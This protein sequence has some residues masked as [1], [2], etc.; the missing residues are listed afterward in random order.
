MITLKIDNPDVSPVIK[1]YTSKAHSAGATTLYVKNTTSFS[2]DDKIVVGKTGNEKTEL[3][4]VSAVASDTTLTI[5]ALDFDHNNDTLVS[6]SD[7]DQVQIYMATSS[8]GTYS[9]QDTANIDWS[10]EKTAWTD[11]DGAS[12]YYYKFRYYNSNSGYVS[13]Y[14]DAI[15]GT[16]WARNTV[17]NITDEILSEANDENEERVSREEILNWMNDCQDDVF[18]RTDER[19]SLR[20]L[21]AEETLYTT[22][23]NEAVDLPDDYDKWQ[24]LNYAFDDGTDDMTYRLRYIPLAEFEYITED[25]DA[26]TSDDLEKFTIDE[27]TG[28]IR[29]YPTPTSSN[30]VL[31]FHYFKDFSTLDSDG[32]VVEIPDNNI[33]KKFCLEKIFKKRRTADDVRIA[34]TYKAEYEQA[35]QY[36]I[37]RYKRRTASRKSFRYNPKG[38]RRWYKY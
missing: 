35:V 38:L 25:D 27:D 22:A 21:N 18:S 28:T 15:I 33:Y 36:M 7:F 31:G 37:S 20:F 16:G 32:D 8:D 12:T 17:R 5:D 6:K 4:A 24:H 1:T 29:L 19:W 2:A 14:S 23:S 9:L 10:Q 11:T 13:D 34:N 30:L 26:D 3:R